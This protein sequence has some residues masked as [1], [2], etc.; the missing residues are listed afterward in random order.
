MR[1]TWLVLPM[2]AVLALGMPVQ[3]GPTTLDLGM[4]RAEASM[5]SKAIGSI[6]DKVGGHA[7]KAAKDAVN[8]AFEINIDGMQNHQADMHNHIYE[9]SWLLVGFGIP[10]GRCNREIRCPSRCAGQ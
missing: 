4:Q 6:G 7:K 9:G 10:A 1:K 2:A 8:Q 3:S 5:F